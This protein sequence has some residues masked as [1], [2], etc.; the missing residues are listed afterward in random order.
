MH[1]SLSEV[2]Q[3]YPVPPW[4]DPEANQQI[5]KSFRGLIRYQ[6]HHLVTNQKRINWAI[7]RRQSTQ[8]T[9]FGQKSIRNIFSI[10]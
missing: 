8:I 4:R 2:E 3:N 9:V 7:I 6:Q 5:I 1:I 10:R